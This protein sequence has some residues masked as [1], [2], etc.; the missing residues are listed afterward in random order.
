MSLHNI[1]IVLQKQGD[2]TCALSKLEES[3]AMR[4]NVYGDKPHPDIALLLNSIGEVLQKHGD[5]VGALSKFQD[6]L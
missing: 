2:L 5:L 1:G 3:L 4:H 6:V